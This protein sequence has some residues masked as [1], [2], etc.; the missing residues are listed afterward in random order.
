MKI[1][2]SY[3]SAHTVTHTYKTLAA[4]TF[5]LL[6]NISKKSNS[7]SPMSTPSDW[8]AR[9]AEGPDWSLIL[10]TDKNGYKIPGCSSWAPS[11]QKPEVQEA[12]TAA[13]TAAAAKSASGSNISS[14]S[15]NRKILIKSSPRFSVYPDPHLHSS[16]ERERGKGGRKKKKQNP[17]NLAETS[18]RMLQNSAVL[19]VLVISASATHEAEQNDSVSLRK[20]RVA[21]QNSGKRQ[22]QDRFLPQGAVLI[23]LSLLQLC[24]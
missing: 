14:S 11:L 17:S 20:S 4:G 13:A 23:C 9:P 6:E 7:S 22:T 18:Q 3:I 19:L 10:R 24:L 2:F 12:A 1:A 21:A 8:L 15:S 16:R 5:N